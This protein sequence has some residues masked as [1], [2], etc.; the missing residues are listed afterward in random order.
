MRTSIKALAAAVAAAGAACLLATPAA[1]TGAGAPDLLVLGSDGVLSRHDGDRLKHVEKKV[2]ITGLGAGDRLVGIDVRPATGG[3]YGIGKSGQ[4]YTVDARSGR[5]TAVGAPVALSGTAVGFDF[6]PTV[7]RIR[8]V[9]D[10]GQNLRLV[11]D[12][13]AVAATDGALAYAPGDRLAGKTPAVSAAG[14]T[15]SVA[16]ATS[17]GLYVIDTRS[18]TLAT[19]GTLPGATPA[20]SPNTGQLFTTGKLGI[21][22]TEANGF[23]ISGTSGAA[24]AAVR[25]EGLLGLLSARA[26]TRVDLATGRLTFLAFLSSTPVGIAFVK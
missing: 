22:I 18:D 5:A 16:G 3:V 14:Y 1:A 7:D 23:D 8:L 20:V 17:T 21:G 4:L 15:N 11:P 12:T 25:T 6:N 26:L 19:Q 13:G 9:T 2:R 24:V 10:A